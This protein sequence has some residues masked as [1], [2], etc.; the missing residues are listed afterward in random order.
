MKDILEAAG[1]SLWKEMRDLALKK[2]TE[3]LVAEG[4]KSLVEVVKRRRIRRDE[5]D[6]AEW[7]KAQNPPDEKKKKK[8]S[9]SK[10]DDD[11]EVKDAGEDSAEDETSEDEESDESGEDDGD[12][13][14]EEDDE[15][16]APDNPDP[17][18]EPEDPES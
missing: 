15:A 18:P 10:K 6:F 2:G 13:D 14:V 3:T 8:S 11:G 4:I 16:E 17:E 12:G 9:K 7:K 5:Y 1:K